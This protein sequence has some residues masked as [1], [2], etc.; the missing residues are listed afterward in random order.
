M[1]GERKMGRGVETKFSKRANVGRLP[2]IKPKLIRFGDVRDLTLGGSP[3]V[4][5][6]GNPTLFQP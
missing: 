6:S 2:Y 4:G 5:E 3:G 1:L